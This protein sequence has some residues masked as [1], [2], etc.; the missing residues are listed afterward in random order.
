[1]VKCVI[2][3]SLNLL[4]R[5][6]TTNCS[7]GSRGIERSLNQQ[8]QCIA[9]SLLSRVL[10]AWFGLFKAENN[11][12]CSTCSADVPAKMFSVW[13][14]F[15]LLSYM[16]HFLLHTFANWSHPYWDPRGVPKGSLLGHG[17]SNHLTLRL[18]FVKCILCGHELEN[19][20]ETFLF[21]CGHL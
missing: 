21:I 2:F 4:C 7:C 18:G 14:R 16:V 13:E 15:T 17:W 12:T 5:T 10:R 11:E 9:V 8:G 20:S 19:K 3:Q 6:H 1:M